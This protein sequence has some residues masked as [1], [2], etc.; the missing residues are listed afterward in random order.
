MKYWVFDGN[1]VVGPFALQEIAARADFSANTLICAE[2][3]SEDAAGWQMASFFDV[4]RFNSVTG[5]LEVIVLPDG[6]SLRAAT[7]EENTNI[8]AEKKVDRQAAARAAAQE[9]AI[10][11]DVLKPGTGPEKAPAPEMQAQENPSWVPPAQVVHHTERKPVPAKVTVEK[12]VAPVAEKPTPQPVR[13]SSEKIKTQPPVPVALANDK[14]DL[15]LPEK[16]TEETKQAPT[17]VQPQAEKSA[18]STPSTPTEKTKEKTKENPGAEAPKTEP[19]AAAPQSAQA[20]ESPVAQ[21]SK[22]EPKEEPKPEV[23]EEKKEKVSSLATPETEILS[24]CTLPIIN[25]VLT[26]SDLPCLPEGG[27]QPVALPAEPEFDLKEFLAENSSRPVTP[28]AGNASVA[29]QPV[30]E[31]TPAAAPAVADKSQSASDPEPEERVAAQAEKS[32]PMPQ[33]PQ[34][35]IIE[36]IE[37]KSVPHAQPQE[38]ALLEQQLLA[39]PTRRS[40]HTVLWM[41]LVVVLVGAG[42]VAWDKYMKPKPAVVEQPAPVQTQPAPQPQP[43]EPEVTPAPVT[44]KPMTAE[45]KALA[46]VQNFQLPGD[47]G[48]IASYFD[49][50]YQD[51]IAQ[52]YTAHWSVEPL[53]KSTYIVKYR[54]TKTRTEPVVY[55]FQADAVRGQLTGA[56][57]N[58]A[59]D[60]IG[61]I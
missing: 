59:L 47:K 12:E 15:V 54:L 27:F 23:K 25:E 32:Y 19:V 50:V 58:I 34:E 61:R 29:A 48:T 6:S 53:H 4:F 57:N 36:E 30:S 56:L 46:A 37:R 9:A 26:Q 5:K 13:I 49:R 20:V 7:S 38:D 55:V 18:I 16:P 28:A 60:L 3:A 8:A 45:E 40:A 35:E 24:T 11:P 42:W 2:D 14:V 52:G 17:T 33:R 43:A 51:R 22:P 10:L 41:L 21:D 39:Q 31:I 1:D 44:P